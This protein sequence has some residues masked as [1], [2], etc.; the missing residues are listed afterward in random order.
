MP[1]G[2]H[3]VALRIAAVGRVECA[4]EADERDSVIGDLIA[5]VPLSVVSAG[6]DAET[7]GGVSLAVGQQAVEFVVVVRMRPWA[8][9]VRS[10]AAVQQRAGA[11]LLRYAE[12]RSAKTVHAAFDLKEVF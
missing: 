9:I 11:E 3:A 12:D 5:G 10:F 8:V 6:C 7:V 1:F 4:E 2:L